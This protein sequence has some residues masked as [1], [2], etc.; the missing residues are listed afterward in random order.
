MS[1]NTAPKL[2]WR[3]IPQA[4]GMRRQRLYA[5]GSETPFFID[6][7]KGV[8]AHK[9]AGSEHGLYGSGMQ[10]GARSGMAIAAE[11]GSGRDVRILKH[12]AEQ[13]ALSMAEG[14]SQ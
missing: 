11:L 14:R 8:L 12:R 6:S 1:G 13:M 7:A 2:V 3:T 9:S 4:C 10:I 5:N